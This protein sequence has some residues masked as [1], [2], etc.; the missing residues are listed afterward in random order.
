MSKGIVS[1]KT[2]SAI[3][4][5]GTITETTVGFTKTGV[6]TR[7]GLPAGLTSTEL[8]TIAKG[9]FEGAAY[10]SGDDIVEGSESLLDEYDRLVDRG[11]DP[12]LTMVRI[13]RG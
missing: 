10:E 8:R 9:L 6:S 2:T 7:H 12:T 5:N 1:S 13:I 4:T 11:D 3:D